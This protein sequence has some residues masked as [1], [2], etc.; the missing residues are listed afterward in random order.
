MSFALFCRA[1][2]ENDALRYS[3][4]SFGGTA[5]YM[6]LGG[7]FGALGAD[8]STLSTNP[9]G[10]GLYNSSEFTFTPSLYVGRTSSDYFNRNS[11]DSKYNFNMGN[12]G[13]VFTMTPVNRVSEEGWKNFQIGLGLNRYQNFNNRIFTEGENQS[14]SLID[15]FTD[16]A[17]G[18]HY[19]EI[20]QDYDGLYAY[21][22]NLA[23]WTYLIDITPPDSSH[24]I[25][26]IPYNQGG[27]MQRFSRET[28]GSTNEFVFSIGA[29]YDNKLYFGATVGFPYVR[30]FSESVYS[31]TV[32]N[33]VDSGLVDFSLYDELETRGAGTNFK[34]GI[35][36]RP[37]GWMRIGGAIHT[38]TF[39]WSM[40]DYWSS[41]LESTFQEGTRYDRSSPEGS[42]DYRLNTPM[43]AIGSL[44][45]LIGDR[46]LI[47]ADYE[48]IDYREARLRGDFYSFFSENDAVRS[49]FTSAS[50]IKIGT[51]WVVDKFSFRGGFGLYGNPYKSGINNGERTSLSCGF[52]Y[53]DKHYFIDLAYVRMMLN[54]DYYLYG[55]DN[56]EVKPAINDYTSNNFLLTVGLKY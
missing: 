39:Y 16:Q 27:V 21:D 56:F 45:F 10:L 14:N 23:W 55:S 51:E 35:I 7:A 9:A 8:F 40:T 46:G 48:Y 50:N 41:Y 36:Y 43:K 29:N 47:S 12:V 32:I 1:Q 33:P 42:Y 49:N 20:E 18:L 25:G 24:Y 31:E 26:A 4:A 30:Y 17:Q 6:A 19:S 52:G 38:P 13:Y 28:T 11:V 2:N 37:T 54:E 15:V 53:R 3:L 44:A 5:R 34:F 22:L